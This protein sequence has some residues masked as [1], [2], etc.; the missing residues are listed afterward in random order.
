[1]NITATSA[2]ATYKFNLPP[3]HIVAGDILLTTT[4]KLLV[5]TA[6]STNIYL[7]QYDYLTG[8]LE[9]TI[10]LNPTFYGGPWGIFQDSGNIYVASS[11]GGIYQIGTTSPYNITLINDTGH[12]IYG[13]SQI[14]SC[15]N[16]EFII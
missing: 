12:S 6:A 11:L 4:N 3:T 9:L 16:S 8:T 2:V 14:P 10:T 5:T 7:L 1:M 15:L 13:A